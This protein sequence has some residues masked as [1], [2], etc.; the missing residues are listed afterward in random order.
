MYDN[1][2]L[3]KCG[4]YAGNW[5]SLLSRATSLTK[6]GGR[7][8]GLLREAP[9]PPF[10]S[11]ERGEGGLAKVERDKEGEWGGGELVL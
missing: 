2:N 8:E 7:G 10:S 5:S 4:W 9:P 6:P 3:Q 11:G 1:L